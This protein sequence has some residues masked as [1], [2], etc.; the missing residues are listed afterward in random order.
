MI[1]ITGSNP[2]ERVVPV[3]LIGV[4]LNPAPA[5]ESNRRDT[6]RFLPSASE[7]LAFHGGCL[8]AR[9]GHTNRSCESSMSYNVHELRRN[10]RTSS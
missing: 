1:G 8:A 10:W 7:V 9:C 2:H 3:P 5:K 4:V 6:V